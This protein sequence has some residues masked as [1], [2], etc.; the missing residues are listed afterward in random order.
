MR[1]LTTA[2]ALTAAIAAT[3]ALPASAHHVHVHRV[4]QSDACVIVAAN[5]G[6]KD[7]ILPFVDSHP[8]HALVHMGQ[9]GADGDWGKY[10]SLDCA[11]YV[12]QRQ[13]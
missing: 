9:P 13:P 12:N 8:I 10:G 6:E 1:T 7:V 5:G 3:T 2:L 4:G 11:G